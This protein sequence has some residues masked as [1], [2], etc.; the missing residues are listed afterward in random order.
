MGKAI[1]YG[2]KIGEILQIIYNVEDYYYINGMFYIKAKDQEWYFALDT[3]GAIHIDSEG[4][5]K[6]E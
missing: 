4:E 5:V 3:I 1:I 2:K 6:N